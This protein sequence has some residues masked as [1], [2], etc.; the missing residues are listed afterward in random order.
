[1]RSGI[2]RQYFDTEQPPHV[3]YV[4][5]S[6]AFRGKVTHLGAFLCTGNKLPRAHAWI[7]R[8]LEDKA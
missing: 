1:M 3:D 7:Y 4:Y 6:N 8:K 2:L 5:T